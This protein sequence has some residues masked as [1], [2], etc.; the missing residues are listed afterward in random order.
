[1]P[2]S[3][4]VRAPWWKVIGPEEG[5]SIWQPEPSRGYVTVNL[6]PENMPYDDFSSGIQV[7]PPGCHVREHGHFQN[8]ELIFIYEGTGR[9]EIEDE[10]FEIGPGATI[11]FGKHARHL[12]ENTGDVDLKLFWVFFPPALEDWFRAIGRPR[13]P[14]EPMPDT[15]SRPENVAD[16]LKAM[17]FVPPRPKAK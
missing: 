5:E 17:K 8:H 3:V 16:I 13:T 2:T 6:T 14:G 9:C 15:F 7:L 1:M 11:L 4:D 10:E 12:L